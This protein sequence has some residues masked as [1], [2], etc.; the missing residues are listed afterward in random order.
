MSR[1]FLIFMMLIVGTSFNSVRTESQ[2][3]QS[4]AMI[5]KTQFRYTGSENTQE[6]VSENICF[7]FTASRINMNTELIEIKATLI[8]FSADTVYFLS[9]SCDGEQYSLLY[10]SAKFDLSPVIY[11]N[12]SF[13]KIM[14]IAPKEHH[15]FLAHFIRKSEEMKIELGFDFYSV[16]KSFNLAQTNLGDLTIFKR[17]KNKQTV[18]WVDEKM[19]N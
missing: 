12:F 9:S 6:K 19:I 8:N 18:L 13:P 17:P 11:C 10:D 2:T 1:Q 4:V 7:N 15:D 16:D 3:N 14:K 5:K